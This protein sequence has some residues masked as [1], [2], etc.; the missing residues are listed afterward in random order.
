[1]ITLRLASA[2]TLSTIGHMV[3]FTYLW[4]QPEWLQ[5]TSQQQ[6]SPLQ[7]SLSQA[8]ASKSNP[9]PGHDKKKRITT[10][11]TQQAST[12]QAT[13][14]HT[15]QSVAATDATAKPARQSPSTVESNQLNYAA[16]NN[17]MIQYLSQEFK[18]RFKY[19]MLA[20]KRGWQ[21]K[22]I[23]G[24]NINHDGKIAH[25]AIEQSSGYRVLD[26]NAI[27]TFKSIGMVNQHL[28]SSLSQDHQLSIPVIYQLTG[29]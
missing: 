15:E 24:L 12:A 16:L 4:Q 13:T 9:P 8:S 6:G 23:L 25:I 14:Q 7:V 18:L 2:V 1:M 5:I 26:H 17:D 21:G 28:Q 10:T 29:S 27:R 20:R 19:P 3:L 11:F 22:V